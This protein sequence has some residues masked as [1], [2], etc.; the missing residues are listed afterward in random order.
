MLLKV[1]LKRII[2][3]FPLLVGITLIS[4]CLMLMAPGDPTAMMIDPKINATDLARIKSNLGLDQPV[5]VQYS[6]WLKQLLKGDLGYSYIN[7]R[8]VLALIMERLPATLLLMCSSLFL[9]LF[10]TIPLGIISAKNNKK[11]IDKSIT[12]FT[13]FGMSIPTFW[14]ALVLIIFFSLNLRLFPTSGMISPFMED[15]GFFA[16]FI[17]VSWHMFLPLLTM[18]IGSLAGLTKYMKTGML[19]VLSSDY[20]KA[21]EASGFSDKFITYKY[22]LKNAVLPI[23]TILG[24]SL[25]GMVGGSFIIEYIFAW[26]GMGRLGV[27]SIFMR[28]FP[29]IMGIILMSSILIIV[30]N[31]ISD[32]LYVLVD[33]RVSYEKSN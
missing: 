29:V 7:G 1:L 12:L 32:I 10:L 20:I 14:L 22:A 31:L 24:L 13:F 3:M 21:A 2:M 27:D 26:P 18:T 6:I 19:S 23:I 11:T 17:N 25:P 4:Y 8:P 15:S 5:A 9:T 16:K 30:G 33:P 28:D